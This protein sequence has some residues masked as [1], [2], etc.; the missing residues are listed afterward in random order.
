M[1]LDNAITTYNV[2]SDLALITLDKI[3]N[4]IRMISEIFGTLAKEN[5]NIDMITHTPS[6]TG[7]V[8][9]SFSICS[10]DLSNALEALARFRSEIPKLRM[11]IDA[12]NTKITINGDAK[13]NVPEIAGNLFSILTNEGVDIKLVATS[14][15]GISYLV[16]GRDETK[17]I[18]SIKREF[19]L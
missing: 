19:N 12:S 17:A 2:T 6:Y 15:T 8:T 16:S 5:I 14:D 4:D 10:T 3:P 9:V 18:D 13:K 7:I 1:L 11:D